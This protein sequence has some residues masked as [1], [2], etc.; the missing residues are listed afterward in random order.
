MIAS[1]DD[2]SL[3]LSA[4]H[5]VVE[6]YAES[7]ALTLSEPADARR[8]TLERD[9]LACHVD[10]TREM[11][12]VREQLQHQLVGAMDVGGVARQCHPSERALPFAEQRADICGH[13]AGER[14][15]IG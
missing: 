10:P 13:E 7:R 3:E 4:C 1:N 8:Q 12:I 15:C 6:C 5:Q 2:R 14:E 9:P 11:C